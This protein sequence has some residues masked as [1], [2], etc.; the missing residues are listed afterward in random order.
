MKQENGLL[1]ER[2]GKDHLQEIELRNLPKLNTQTHI[3]IKTGLA[4]IDQAR[5]IEDLHRD[6]QIKMWI[7]T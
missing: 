3:L 1:I 6:L 4:E 2:A 5:T 7:G